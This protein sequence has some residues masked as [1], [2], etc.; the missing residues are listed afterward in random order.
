VLPVARATRRV[1]WPAWAAGLLLTLSLVAAGAWFWQR[2]FAAER[3]ARHGVAATSPA[4]AAVTGGALATDSAMRARQAQRDAEVRDSAARA[5]NLAV[6]ADS[7]PVLAPV[8]AADSANASAY[9]VLLENT[10]G[11][12]GAILQLQGKFPTVPAASYGL[13]L[14]NRLFELVAGAYP[15]RAGAESLLTDLRTRSILPPGGGTVT[16][17]PYAFL[18][19]ANVA[20]ADVPARLTRA[21][22]QRGQPVY[23]L[24]QPNG[25]AILYFGAY[26]N[27][28]QAAL[29]VPAV[30]KFGITPTLVYRIGRVF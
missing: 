7:F 13:S 8:N 20:A 25:T 21:V 23:A 1:P 28:E 18:A 30:R 22:T 4:A 14:R 15:T 17:R 11:L 12:A 27:P 26:E 9:A 5:A 6:A 24:R 10:N 3:V 19:Q 16:T 2:P 29:A